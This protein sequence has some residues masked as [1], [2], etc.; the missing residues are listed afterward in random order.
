MPP[1]QK[2]FVKQRANTCNL[3]SS[4]L[5]LHEPHRVFVLQGKHQAYSQWSRGKCRH[6][7]RRPM[8]PCAPELNPFMSPI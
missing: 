4:K 6:P 2:E 7:L 5:P 1:R 8:I 3:A